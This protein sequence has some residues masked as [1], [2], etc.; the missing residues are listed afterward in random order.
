MIYD[1]PTSCKCMEL[2]TLTETI[3]FKNSVT[4]LFIDSADG[5]VCK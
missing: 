2:L 4:I 3:E 5:S 1:C